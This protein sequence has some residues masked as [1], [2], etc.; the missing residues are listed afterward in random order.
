M[1]EAALDR[2]GRKRLDYLFIEDVGNLICPASHLLGEHLRVVVLS[3][4]E[5]DD[6]PGKYPKAFRSS[7]A[8]VISKLDLLPYVP[9]SVEEA[10]EDAR[11]VQPTLEVLPV[12][13]LT[14]EGMEG[15]Y[16]LLQRCRKTHCG[17]HR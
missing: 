7:Q 17:E 2:L 3:T 11:Q 9:F 15:W 14:G 10:A 4:T 12:S 13:A 1:V 16:R 8:V 5:G 6:K